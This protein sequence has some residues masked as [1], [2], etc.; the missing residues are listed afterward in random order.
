MNEDTQYRSKLI[1]IVNAID[2]FL[3][4]YSKKWARDF[5]W[6][7]S[8]KLLSTLCNKKNYFFLVFV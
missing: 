6:E 4:E 1:G 7:N 5:N 3:D 2:C 8:Q